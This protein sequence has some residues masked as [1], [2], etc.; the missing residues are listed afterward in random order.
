MPLYTTQ[1][2]WD[3]DIN[4]EGAAEKFK[5][6]DKPV[7]ARDLIER[8]I[9]LRVVVSG[10]GEP[11]LRLPIGVQKAIPRNLTKSHLTETG[12]EHRRE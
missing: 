11:V 12:Q 7:R 9:A 4:P 5:F 8:A 3:S 1:M 2:I 10:I 6:I